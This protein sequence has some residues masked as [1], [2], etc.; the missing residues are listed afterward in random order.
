MANGSGLASVN[1]VVV[2]MLE[3]RSRQYL[4]GASAPP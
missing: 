2:L 4:A 1:S 3:N